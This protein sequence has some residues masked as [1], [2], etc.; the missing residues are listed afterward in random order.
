MLVLTRK[1]SEI[2]IVANEIK[3]H[4]VKVGRDNVKLGFDAPEHI[5]VQ[6]EEIH[7]KM[8]QEDPAKIQPQIPSQDILEILSQ[9]EELALSRGMSACGF[10]RE[11]IRRFLDATGSET[12]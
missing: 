11:V 12:A 4:V 5:K 10:L 9:V 6:R 2:V 7:E 1:E 3:V 8:A